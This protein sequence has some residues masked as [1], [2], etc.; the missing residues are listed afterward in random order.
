[1]DSNINL[2]LIV[3]NDGSTDKTEEIITKMQNKSFNNFE[4][5]LLS[6]SKNK[7][8]AE[9]LKT[10]FTYFIKHQEDVSSKDIVITMDADNTHPPA[11][12]LK[13]FRL[14]RD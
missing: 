4:V 13:M 7:G 10:G 14:I 9:S 12:V 2:R 6:H 5:K 8:L 11:L 3:V 1:L